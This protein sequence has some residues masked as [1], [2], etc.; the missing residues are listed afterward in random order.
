MASESKA[1]SDVADGPGGASAELSSALPDP[2]LPTLGLVADL[3]AKMA[4]MLS[5]V[6]G[7]ACGVF[8]FGGGAVW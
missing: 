2:T 5:D 7:V 6:R 8:V 4:D 3:E 1:G